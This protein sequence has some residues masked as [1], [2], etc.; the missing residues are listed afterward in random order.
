MDE[1]ALDKEIS[2]TYY[3]VN[4]IEASRQAQSLSVVEIALESFNE[5]NVQCGFTFNSQLFK[6]NKKGVEALLRHLSMTTSN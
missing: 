4:V 3:C 6:V 1:I 5:I 2:F